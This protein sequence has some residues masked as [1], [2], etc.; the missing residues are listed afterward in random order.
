MPYEDL[1]NMDKDKFEKYVKERYEDQINWY[2]K[3]SSRNKKLYNRFQWSAIVLSAAI[4]VLVVT[5]EGPCKWITVVLSIFLT[6]TT[7]GLKTFKFQENWINYRTTAETL[8]KEKHYYHA[9]ISEYARV[10][11]KEQLFIER[12][13]RLIS[14]ENTLWIAAFKKKGKAKEGDVENPSSGG[15]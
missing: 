10:N 13:E 9:G 6:I 5:L 14:R 12:V 2:S 7:A 15:L 3:Q 11:N 8:K 4:P 1:P